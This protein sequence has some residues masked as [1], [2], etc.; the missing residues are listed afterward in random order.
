MTIL[1]FDQIHSLG[2]KR[3]SMPIEQYFGEMYLLASQKQK[4][5]GIA[6][7]LAE[8]IRT[9]FDIILLQAEYGNIDWDVVNAEVASMYKDALAKHMPL[10]DTLNDYIDLFA[11][12]FVDVTRR[13]VDEELIELATVAWI[14]NQQGE[15]PQETDEHPVS[16]AYYISEDRA[17]L[18]GE[19]EAN[20]D[21]NYE[22]FRDAVENG[23]T[24]K[25]WHTML[26]NRV[27]ETHR[28]LEGVQIPIEKYFMV[29]D[30]LM[31]YPRDVEHAED[32]PEEI[33]GCRC[34]VTYI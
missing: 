21:A 14:A 33:C 8:V 6:E 17:V 22:D 11:D 34:S 7:D 3:R 16:D 10:D 23:M 29:G 20:S 12:K 19:E 25:I 26:D 2:L 27:R 13:H 15:E 1:S 9:A 32:Y 28:P 5:I 4:R 18:I 31:L 30:A 24:E